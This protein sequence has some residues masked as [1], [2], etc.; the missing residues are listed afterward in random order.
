MHQETFL[1]EEIASFINEHFIAIIVDKDERPDIAMLYSQ[2]SYQFFQ[3]NGWPLNLV[4][5]AEQQPFLW[6]IICQDSLFTILCN[7]LFITGIMR[8]MF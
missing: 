6:Q 1:D 5:N 3:K 8:K 4:L 2:I 7:Q